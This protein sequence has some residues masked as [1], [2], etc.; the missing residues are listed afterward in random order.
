LLLPLYF[1]LALLLSLQVDLVLTLLL[2]ALFA[3]L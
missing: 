3:F 1:C 2:P